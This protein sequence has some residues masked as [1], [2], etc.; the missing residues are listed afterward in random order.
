MSTESSAASRPGGAPAV[1][2]VVATRDRPERLATLLE[3]L[4]GQSLAADSFEVVVVDDGSRPDTAALLARERD[5]AG[6]SL[7]VVSRTQ[8]SGP[9]VARNEGWRAAG[10]PVVAF[11]D[12]DCEASPSWLAE[13]LAASDLAGG[14]AVQGRTEPNPAELDRM[15]PFTRTLAVRE[16]GP[17]YQTCNM[18]YPR[19][20][21]ERLGGF[22]ERYPAPG[23]EDTDL[24]WRALELGGEIAFAERALVLHAV[25]DLGPAGYLKVALRW[26]DGMRVFRRHPGLR[27]QVF[28]YGVFWKES[29]ALLA[30]SALAL[31]LAR[32]T[33]PTALFVLPYARQLA[34]RCAATGSS[35]GYIPYLALYDAV[36]AYAAIRGALR[37]RVIVI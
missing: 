35:S 20:L 30:Q 34:S 33:P 18:F 19:E 22:D 24:A 37:Q 36:E 6:P 17:F 23:G 29:H 5:R 1:S 13:G 26:S 25:E 3:S 21:L 15:G 32:R 10:A 11:T 14:V 12:D 9:A 2:V 8:S 4:R 7:R 28:S 27:R 31:A 16:A